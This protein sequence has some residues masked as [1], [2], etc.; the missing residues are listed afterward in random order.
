MFNLSTRSVGH[1]QHK[2]RAREQQMREHFKEDKKVITEQSPSIATRNSRNLNPNM[3]STNSNNSNN[4]LHTNA[5]SSGFATSAN[6]RTSN[7][8][9]NRSSNA[10]FPPPPRQAPSFTQTTTDFAP[11]PRT[12][13][14]AESVLLPQPATSTQNLGQ[15]DNA[16]LMKLEEELK[17]IHK[18]LQAH[19][20][21]CNRVEEKQHHQNIQLSEFRKVFDQNLIAQQDM[22]NTLHSIQ[23]TSR[24][25]MYATAKNKLDIFD[26]PDSK[27]STQQLEKGEKVVLVHPTIVDE[28]G[29]IWI[30]V[31]R[32]YT[33]GHIDEKYVVFY[34]K[35]TSTLQFEILGL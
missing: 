33:N 24:A 28:N 18:T 35:V 26:A 8:N 4:N 9:P 7:L 15:I 6:Q 10:E 16:R 25:T 2:N 1:L 32:L 31:R 17:Q 20:L 3:R 30:L 34:D 13:A 21:L 27:T 19:E 23:T 5:F 22:K 29:V 11:L 12:L 14:P